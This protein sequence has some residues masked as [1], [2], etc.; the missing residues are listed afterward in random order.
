MDKVDIVSLNVRG[1]RG[2]KR[3]T[4]FKWILGNK[5]NIALLQETFVQN[6]LFQNLIKIGMTIYYI[7]FQ[8]HHVAEEYVLCLEKI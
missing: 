2:N 7:V 5:I 3:H 8:T 6:L 1:L 4:I